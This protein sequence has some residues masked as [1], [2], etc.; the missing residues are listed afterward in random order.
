MEAAWTPFDVVKQPNPFKKETKWKQWK[1]SMLTYLHCQNGHANLPLTYLKCEH[2]ALN[3][4]K[5][6]STVHDQ[7]VE[8]AVLTGPEYNINN[9]LAYDSLQSLTLNG[10][11]WAW[12]NAFRHTRDGR[13]VWGSIIMKEIM[14]RPEANK[15]NMKHK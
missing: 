4:N 7:L 2:D 5:V 8:Y 6:F 11:A 13:N 15:D 3:H 9:G 12:I 14:P 10:L 1:E